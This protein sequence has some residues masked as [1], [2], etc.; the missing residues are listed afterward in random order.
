M[1]TYGISKMGRNVFGCLAIC[2]LIEVFVC[3]INSFRLCGQGNYRK[4][5]YTP[6]MNLEFQGAETEEGEGVLVCDTSEKELANVLKDVNTCVGS[7]YMDLYSPQHKM[8]SY[9]LYYTDEAAAYPVR[10]IEREHVEQI[11]RSKWITCHFAGVSEE[12]RLSFPDMET[13]EQLIVRQIIVNE[14]IPFRISMMRLLT[15]FIVALLFGILPG[16]VFWTRSY[17]GYVQKSILVI[18]TVCFLGVVWSFYGAAEG[19]VHIRK[20][21]GDLYSQQLVDALL[22]KEVSLSLKPS[23]DFMKLENPYDIT[24]RAVA[25]MRRDIDYIWDAAYYDGNFYVY[26]GVVPALLL[27]VPFKIITGYYLSTAFAVAFFTSVYLIFLNLLITACIKKWLPEA[28]FAVYPCGILVMDAASGA[29]LFVSGARFY[30][31]VYA[32]GLAFAAV[33]LYLLFSNGFRENDSYIRILAGSFCLALTVGCRPPMLFYSFLLIPYFYKRIKNKKFRKNI[34]PFLFLAI[35]YIVIAAALMIY[36]YIRFDTV[37]EFGQNYQIT[38]TDIGKGS[39]FLSSLPWCIWRG[40]F[41]PLLINAKF[42]F[43]HPGDSGIDFVGYMLNAEFVLPIFSCA[44]LLYCM[45][46]PSYWKKWK[47]H[48]GKYLTGVLAVTVGLGWIVAVIV[49]VSAG[50]AGRYT[51]EAIPLLAFGA[52]LLHCNRICTESSDERRKQLIN[53]MAAAM[54]FSVGVAFFFGITGEYDAIR[55]HSPVF[56]YTIERICCFWK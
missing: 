44:P 34:V 14:S 43:F 51:L 18:M 49:F 41:Q 17:Q 1:I 33:G 6:E 3:N 11:E 21:E 26:F 48:R 38:V 53:I 22:R 7:I 20:A 25:E 2:L 42:P 12:L 31:V 32:A 39:Y 50:I 40:M 27:F 23:D 30:E 16:T 46:F 37:F 9:K 29:L 45:F 24:E 10:Y 47:R 15:L 19:E 4:K 13:G 56:Y 55:A 36:N 52:V 35:P 8:L 54:L 5:V 28:P